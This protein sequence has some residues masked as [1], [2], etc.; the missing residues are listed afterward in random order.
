M[1]CTLLRIVQAAVS[2]RRRFECAIHSSFESVESGSE[3]QR[4]QQQQQQED[5]TPAQPR[6]EDLSTSEHL[7]RTFRL[8][9]EEGDAEADPPGMTFLRAAESQEGAEGGAAYADAPASTSIDVLE[10]VSFPSSPATVEGTSLA[11]D[12]RS[13]E[14]YT[15][16]GSALPS[17]EA[18]PTVFPHVSQ[19]PSPDSAFSPPLP[20]AFTPPVPE[21]IP[22]V[23]VHEV[24]GSERSSSDSDSSSD[25]RCSVKSV[26]LRC[27]EAVSPSSGCKPAKLIRS[28][29]MV[30]SAER[31]T[32]SSMRWV[33][34]L[35]DAGTA[36]LKEGKQEQSQEQ[37]EQQ[38]QEQGQEDEERRGSDLDKTELLA[39]SDWLLKGKQVLEWE[40]SSGEDDEARTTSED[41]EV[42]KGTEE[43]KQKDNDDYLFQDDD[44]DDS[45]DEG[46]MMVEASFEDSFVD[47]GFV[48]L[49]VEDYDDDVIIEENE[50]DFERERMEEEMMLEIRKNLQERCD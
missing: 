24:S 28:D 14:P 43:E 29:A 37:E 42:N 40:S 50:E 9:F 44:D 49:E 20:G 21:S 8:T 47:D 19:A 10:D 7:S 35:Q 45:G 12:T 2:L 38:E 6:A 22:K 4:E 36:L 31:E 11:L 27:G 33:L 16:C 15:P 32:N 23:Q 3:E 17:P 13:P 26:R 1:A 18:L 48:S 41:E 25:S 39:Y 30:S 46:D 34:M 5:H